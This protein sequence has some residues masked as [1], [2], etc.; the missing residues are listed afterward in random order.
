MSRNVFLKPLLVL[1]IS[2]LFAS[3]CKTTSAEKS[4]TKHILG[5][6]SVPP[7]KALQ[8]CEDGKNSPEAVRYVRDV[9]TW[10]MQKNP[11]TFAGPYAPGYFCFVIIDGGSV[12][13]SASV[14]SR[15]I[16]VNK[17]LLAMDHLKDA[18]VA[19]V[20]AHELAH[21]TMQHKLR[22][23]DAADLP[24]D[25]DAIEGK[26]RLNARAKWIAAVE[27]SRA[28]LVRQAYRSGVFGDAATLMRDSSILLRIRS[29]NP[30]QTPKIFD[31]AAKALIRLMADYPEVIAAP[32]AQILKS[33][34]FLDRMTIHL[35]EL[36]ESSSSLLNYINNGS[37]ICMMNQECRDKKILRNLIQFST[38]K[39]KPE[40]AKTCDLELPMADDPNYY[41]PYVQWAE[42]QADE[43]GFELYLRAGLHPD[44][45][46]T[47]MEQM[48]KANGS[49]ESCLEKIKQQN[50]T[51]DRAGS[52]IADAHP[53]YCFRY[54]DIKVAEMSNHESDYREL[55]TA[56]KTESIPGLE[57]ALERI[58]LSLKA[59]GS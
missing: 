12:N 29:A 38:S 15:T 10:M 13:A 25:Y 51:P 35:D 31:N 48:M 41:P 37:E 24:P 44:R 33:W 23:P 1:I 2:C 32:N 43:V 50:T 5:R 6:T 53:A 19:A 52:D 55:I 30:P 34:Q 45:F 56:A 36:T 4:R 17:S 20:L 8:S 54:H 42:Q 11:N 40:I 16:F 28:N 26:R 7:V 27:A 58:R 9:A 49:F 57:G 59:D 18:D 39:I 22:E 47:Y 3:A 46:T 21:I 14:E